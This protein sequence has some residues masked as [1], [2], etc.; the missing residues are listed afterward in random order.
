MATNIEAK[1]KKKHNGQVGPI[2][3]KVEDIVVNVKEFMKEMTGKYAII[4]RPPLPTP[5]QSEAGKSGGP[6]SVQSAIKTEAAQSVKKP[7]EIVPPDDVSINTGV[8]LKSPVE[9]SK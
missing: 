7:P 3:L 1:T 6:Q 4:D 2:L 9:A 5:A 8:S